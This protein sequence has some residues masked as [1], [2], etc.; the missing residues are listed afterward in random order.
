M[1]ASRKKSVSR[2][3]ITLLIVGAV[4]FAI[5]FA[6]YASTSTVFKGSV[7]TVSKRLVPR[8]PSAPQATPSRVHLRLF[9]DANGNGRY[10]SG[11][12]LFAKK[13]GVD[14]LWR[15]EGVEPIKVEVDQ[16]ED[17]FTK[18]P[19]DKEITLYLGNVVG[20]VFYS[21]DGINPF[22]QLTTESVFNFTLTKE[23]PTLD[24]D[25][26]ILLQ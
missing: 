20:G 24:V 13:G 9:V 26:G 15:Y 8:T 17:T 14:V 7:E 4:V 16:G 12:R 6:T 5:F 23:H 10:D 19:L 11:E 1:I 18:I 25:I 2:N 22:G 3:V 21:S